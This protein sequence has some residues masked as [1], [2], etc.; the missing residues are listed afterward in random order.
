MF[1]HDGAP[2]GQRQCHSCYAADAKLESE[3]VDGAESEEVTL[4]DDHRL[5]LVNRFDSIY[6]GMKYFDGIFR[7]TY[8]NCNKVT[9]KQSSG[10]IQ[11]LK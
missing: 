9:V 1:L 2:T 10:T 6:I 11:W 5:K 3:S 4:S 8:P 7:E